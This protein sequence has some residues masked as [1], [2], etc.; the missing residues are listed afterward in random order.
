MQMY[1]RSFIT[2][3]KLGNPICEKQGFPMETNALETCFKDQIEGY[4]QSQRNED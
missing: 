3:L 4:L 2:Y 1:V